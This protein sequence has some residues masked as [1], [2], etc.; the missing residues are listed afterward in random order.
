MRILLITHIFP[1]SVDGGSKII[2]KLGNYLS[3]YH[4]VQ[5]LTTDCRTTDDFVT[6]G[7]APVISGND[8]YPV[9]RLPVYKTLRKSFKLLS[10]ITNN[11]PYLTDLFSIAQTGPVFKPFS[12]IKTVIS[13]Y[14]FRPQVIIAGPFPTAVPLYAFFLAK[15][16]NSRLVVVPCFHENDIAFHSRPLISVLKNSRLIC[17]LTKHEIKYLKKRYRLNDFN[18]F[19]LQAGIDSDF[20]IKKDPIPPKN[21]NLLF[22]ANFSAH[23]RAE[24]LIKAFVRLATDF[25]RLSL[26]LAG[27]ETLYLPKI[28]ELIETLPVSISS[29]IKLVVGKYDQ[30]LEKKFLSRSSIL[31]LPSV[32]ESFGMVF[33]EAWARKKPVIGAGIPA[34]TELI[35]KARGGL[36]FK[37]DNLTELVS[38]I[39]QLLNHPKLS[40]RLALSGYNYVK[41]NLVWDTIGD[42]LCQKLQ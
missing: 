22:L 36:I 16:F 32:H 1:P 23:K 35:T 29:R 39:R 19:L 18:F 6:P 28:K 17:T 42:R 40:R 10:L 21:P 34:V 38:S 14:R 25:P 30:K 7:S 13:L 41:N 2:Y 26:T 12:F 4:Q 8:S 37:T 5:C 27:Q 3:R 11:I 31:V 24:I 33:I 9:Y 20:L 15:L